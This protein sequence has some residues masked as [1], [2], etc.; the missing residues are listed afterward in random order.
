[1]DIYTVHRHLFLSEYL[2]VPG[3]LL[4]R[5]IDVEGLV[6]SKQML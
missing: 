3:D 4:N 5:W 1:M 2:C 6:G